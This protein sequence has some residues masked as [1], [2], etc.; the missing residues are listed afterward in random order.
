M[1]E[2]HFLVMQGATK[3]QRE[4]FLKFKEPYVRD[5]WLRYIKRMEDKANG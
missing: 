3:A 2:M 5:S 1:D 4:K